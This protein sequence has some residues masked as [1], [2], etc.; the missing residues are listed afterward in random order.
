MRNEARF[1]QVFTTA[2]AVANGFTQEQIEG[3]VARDRWRRLRRGAFCV[4][5]AWTAASPE[6][7][8]VLLAEAVMRVRRQG[9]AYAF[10]H[11]TAAAVHGLPVARRLLERVTLTVDPMH[12]AGPGTQVTTRVRSPR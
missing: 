3:A 9:G 7:R 5:D 2:D 10:S 12:G 4:T 8:H 6:R 1:P 11:V